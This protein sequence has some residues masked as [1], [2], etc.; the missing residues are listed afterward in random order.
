MVFAVSLGSFHADPHTENLFA[1]NS[2]INN[3]PI[4]AFVNFGMLWILTTSM[5][6]AMKDLFLNFLLRDSHALVSAL[7]TLG[8]IGE[9]ANLAALEREL[10]LMMQQ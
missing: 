3:Q 7:S 6:K 5:K 1:Q 10:V 2:T 4:S 8:F 9:G